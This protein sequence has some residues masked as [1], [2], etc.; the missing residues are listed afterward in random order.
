MAPVDVEDPE[1]APKAMTWPF[2]YQDQQR[3]VEEDEDTSRAGTGLEL[4]GPKS[5]SR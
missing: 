1:E 5:L 4:L 2:P 3:F